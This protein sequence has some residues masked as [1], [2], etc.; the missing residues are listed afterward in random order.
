MP[1]KTRYN[2]QIVES[3][4]EAMLGTDERLYT[5]QCCYREYESR[6]LRPLGD[7]QVC[8]ECYET[9]ATLK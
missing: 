4:W 7:I 6:E 1:F 5:C 2:A 8:A 3:K 9:M